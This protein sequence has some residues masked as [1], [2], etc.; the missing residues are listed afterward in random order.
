M[1]D[2]L[3]ITKK[4]LDE[5]LQKKETCS[6]DCVRPDSKSMRLIHCSVHM[7]LNILV[8]QQPE[9]ESN[10]TKKSAG[11]L[12]LNLP[13]NVKELRHFLGMVQYYRDMW[14]RRSEMLAPIRSSTMSVTT[15]ILCQ[16]ILK[17]MIQGLSARF[18]P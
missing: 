7:I 16:I 15:L 5:H 17:Y 13:N 9:M 1:D 2:L 10:P 12:P 4:I 8:I 11:I 18:L 3:I 6:P 14:A